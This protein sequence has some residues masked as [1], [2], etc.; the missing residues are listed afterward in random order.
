MRIKI[1]PKKLGEEFRLIFEHKDYQKTRNFLNDWYWVEDKKKRIF[2][3]NYLWYK[4]SY[5]LIYKLKNKEN[6]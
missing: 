1:P 6:L 4:L 2:I 5:P 3:L